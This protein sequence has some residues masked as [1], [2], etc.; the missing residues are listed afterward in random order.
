MLNRIVAVLAMG[1]AG[2]VTC[3]TVQAQS[4]SLDECQAR[5]E[6]HYPLVKQYELIDKTKDYNISNAS[7]R[8]LPQLTLG[9]KASYQSDV[10]SLPLDVSSLGLPIS[11]PTVK[12]D[13]YGATLDVSQLVYD[14]GMTSALK[15]SAVAEAE[16]SK[17]NND[18]AMYSL[19]GRVNEVYFALLMLQ[20][21]LRSHQLYQAQLGRTEEKLRASLKGGI[22]TPADV[23][24]VH[25]DFLK[26]E[27]TGAELRTQI[28]AYRQVLSLLTGDSLGEGITL[29]RPADP[30]DGRSG[31][32]PE[33][34]AFGAQQDQL[35]AKSQE[36]K[37]SVLP[38][39]GL[40]AQGGYS[41]PGLNMLKNEFAPYYVVGAR[42]SWN[43]G[44]LYTY[45]N[46]RKTLELQ[47]QMV[48]AQA[49][50]FR[51]NQR[52]EAEQQVQQKQS[53]EDQQRYDQE[54]VSLKQ[55][56]YQTSE[57]KLVG[58]T[59]SATD[60]MRDLTSLRLAEQDKIAHDLKRLKALYD[61][62]WTAGE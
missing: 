61:L 3:P 28:T 22:V 41:R 48:G 43:I 59:L 24:A 37:A 42:L 12:K 9:A 11:I 51:L 40:F 47:K 6:R 54:I 19:R 18:V 60:A 36:L 2:L 20:E 17:K 23:D 10:T 34:K 49:E 13:Q 44:A 29:T 56:I 52:V 45:G 14:G 31:E 5:A 50:A 1:T 25:V 57:A 55:R 8:Y 26:G 27:Q 30:Q 32:R 7:K 4:L 58:G 16:L 39:L 46:K 38:T 21:Q 53:N 33:L 35:S 62:R 15:K